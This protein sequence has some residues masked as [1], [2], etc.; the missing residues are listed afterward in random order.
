MNISCDMNRD[1]LPLYADGS[2]SEDSR[3]AV[4]AHLRAC[5]AC[6]A[7]LERMRA[8]D[9]AET[10]SAPR[11]APARLLA[12]YGKKRRRRTAL[13]WILLPVLIL[14]LGFG[15]PVAVR[16]GDILLCQSPVSAGEKEPG[17]WDLNA[18][19]LTGTAEE[20]GR[21]GLS[22][23]T[24]RIAVSA[25]EA[26]APV[27]VTLWAVEDTPQPILEGQTGGDALTLVFCNLSAARR[28]LVRIQGEDAGTVTVSARLSLWEALR[29]AWGEIY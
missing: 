1:L 9:F 11:E 6:R 13:L 21:W 20:V 8:P 26:P 23:N 7:E 25:P 22:S 27:T 14:A 2:C 4:E 24:T 29:T 19:D 16:A 5:P 15:G 10:G 18:G 3:A 17:I 12:A 28:Y